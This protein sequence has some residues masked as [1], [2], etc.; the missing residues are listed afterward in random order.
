MRPELR[1]TILAQFQGVYGGQYK[2]DFEDARRIH[3]LL[4]PWERAKKNVAQRLAAIR[5]SNG[6]SVAVHY[7]EATLDGWAVMIVVNDGQ[8][9]RTAVNPMQLAVH[10]FLLKH[11]GSSGGGWPERTGIT[12]KWLL[13]EEE[14]DE[15]R[16]AL[17]LWRQS[18]TEVS[19]RN[20]WSE[21]DAIKEIC[22][23]LYVVFNLCEELRIDIQPFFDAVHAAN[24]TKTPAALSPTRKILKGPDYQ[25]P[26]IAGLL[27]QYRSDQ[28]NG[29]RL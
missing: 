9:A 17:S 12:N 27:E 21:T 13:I 6:E 20:D 23:V 25:P 5:P 2:L 1:E 28:E 7:S 22:D 11:L 14:I 15:L 3:M 26:D 16:G 18:R 29:L 10:E 24:M 8:T 19:Q 4:P